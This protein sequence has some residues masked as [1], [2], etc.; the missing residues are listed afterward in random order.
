MA[1]DSQTIITVTSKSCMIGDAPIRFTIWGQSGL[2]LPHYL[3]VP[4]DLMSKT[5]LITAV[6]FSTLENQFT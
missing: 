5:P 4:Q 3:V 1:G 2:L 6:S